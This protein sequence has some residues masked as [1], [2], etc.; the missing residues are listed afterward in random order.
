MLQKSSTNLHVSTDANTDATSYCELIEKRI[1]AIDEGLKYP[2][3]IKD[4][5]GRKTFRIEVPFLHNIYLN[6]QTAVIASG[7]MHELIGRTW[8]IISKYFDENV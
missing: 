2:V 5:G 7:L 6:A 8:P 3:Q 1:P 4:D